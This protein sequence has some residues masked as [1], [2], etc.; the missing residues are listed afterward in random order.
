MSVENAEMEFITCGNK[1]T[2]VIFEPK[3]KKKESLYGQEN[4][5]FVRGDR[6]DCE[7]DQVVEGRRW[8][9]DFDMIS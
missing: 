1:S 4:D 8:G 3:K 7:G 5:R 9:M 6:P 2:E